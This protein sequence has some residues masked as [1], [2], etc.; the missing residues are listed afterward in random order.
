MSKNVNLDEFFGKISSAVDP[1][2]ASFAKYDFASRDMKFNFASFC[3]REGIGYF[4]S[5][6]A[7][8]D[9][10]SHENKKGLDYSFLFFNVGENA[11]K[12]KA[13]RDEMTLGGGEF[14]I[15]TMKNE[16]SGSHEFE[17]KIYKTQCVSMKTS[18]AKELG[19]LDGLNLNQAVSV[20][21]RKIAP[22]QRMLLSELRNSS[23]FEGKMFE[24]YME[25]KILELIYKSFEN[26]G[27]AKDAS[28]SPDDVKTLEKAR[29]ILLRDMRNPPSIKELARACATN[30]FKLKIGFKKYFGDTIYGML[31]NERLNLAKEL[32]SRKEISVKEAALTVGYVNVSH[33][34]KIFKRK[35]DILPTQALKEKK[36]FMF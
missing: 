26:K 9:F 21:K 19:L 23:V 29:E 11:V 12:F 34:A 6:I 24:I 36:Y 33:F 30:E 10:L 15:G 35:F 8:N 31:A 27:A 14:W 4:Q 1:A 16:L 28:F 20:K 13:G 7:C 2:R 18:L 22:A 3:A 5:D 32:L 25:S 17:N